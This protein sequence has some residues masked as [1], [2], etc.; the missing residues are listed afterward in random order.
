MKGSEWECLGF[1]HGPKT[2]FKTLKT[3]LNSEQ[4]MS[5][6]ARDTAVS[7]AVCPLFK[8]CILALESA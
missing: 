6:T 8:N 5:E 3:S 7:V 2:V 4:S 1:N